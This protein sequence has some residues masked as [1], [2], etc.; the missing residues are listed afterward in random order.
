MLLFRLKQP[1]LVQAGLSLNQSRVQDI[2]LGQRYRSGSGSG[3]RCIISLENWSMFTLL[4]VEV[5]NECGTTN[6]EFPPRNVFP[7]YRF[8]KHFHRNGLFCM[9]TIKQMSNGI[10]IVTNAWKRFMTESNFHGR[11]HPID[12]SLLIVRH[13]F[14]WSLLD[15]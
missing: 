11:P 2:K 3:V 5:I 4:D 10:D 14:K 1:W 12:R 6:S 9:L 8:V 7:G 15:V 13:T